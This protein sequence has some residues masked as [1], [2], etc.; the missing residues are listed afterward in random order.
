MRLFDQ[1][2]AV[3]LKVVRQAAAELKGRHEAR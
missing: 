2:D 3:E 1:L